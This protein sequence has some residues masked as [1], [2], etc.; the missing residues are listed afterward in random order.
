MDGC[1]DLFVHWKF[2]PQELSSLPHCDGKT[3]LY[4]N[5]TPVLLYL[6]VSLDLNRGVRLCLN[7]F[8]DFNNNNESFVNT[9]YTR[10]KFESVGKCLLFA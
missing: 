4:V 5:T 1:V 7:C 10:S 3:R 9:E 2:V 8:N 6:C